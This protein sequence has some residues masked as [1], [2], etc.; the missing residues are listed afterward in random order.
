MIKSGL[1]S[2]DINLKVDATGKITHGLIANTGRLVS[3]GVPVNP[4]VGHINF[5]GRE[6]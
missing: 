2:R 5:T 1:Q 6:F 3:R 4:K